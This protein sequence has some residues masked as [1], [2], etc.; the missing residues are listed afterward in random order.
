MLVCTLCGLWLGLEREEKAKR[1][2][3]CRYFEAIPE[4]RRHVIADRVCVSL[5]PVVDCILED[6]RDNDC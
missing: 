1:S 2:T 5:H 3:I 4:Y 6:M